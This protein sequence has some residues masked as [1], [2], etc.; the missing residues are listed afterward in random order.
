VILQ[1]GKFS[2]P[3]I[4][5]IRSFFKIAK[6]SQLPNY[7]ITKLFNP[8]DFMAAPGRKLAP[9]KPAT[10]PGHRQRRFPRFAVDARIQVRKFQRGCC[11]GGRGNLSD[12]RLW[13]LDACLSAGR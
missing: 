12:A 5:S 8:P 2:K 9:G 6:F 1:L 11:C 13:S 4:P 10:L 7:P 3:K